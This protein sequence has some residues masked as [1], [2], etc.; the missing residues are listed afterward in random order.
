MSQVIVST[1]PTVPGYRI[2]RIMGIVSGMTA[3]TRGVGGKIVAGIQSMVVGEVSAFTE[4]IIKAKDEALRRTM[5]QAMQLGANAI[6]GLDFETSEVFQ[7]VVLISTTGT[8]V[9][10]EP[11]LPPP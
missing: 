7:T 9:V 3:R 5:E 6:I 10:I 2:I 4:E 11:E 1:T 8:A